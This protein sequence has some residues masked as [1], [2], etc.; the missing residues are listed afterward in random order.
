MTALVQNEL[1][2]WNIVKYNSRQQVS[3]DTWSNK[4]LYPEVI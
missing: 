2:D 1:G 3:E 4:I